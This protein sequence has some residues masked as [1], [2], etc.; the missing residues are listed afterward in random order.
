MSER[1]PDDRQ[2]RSQ[3]T[4]ACHVLLLTM[5]QETPVRLTY[6]RAE[7]FALQQV[8]GILAHTHT[9]TRT[10]AH[11]HSRLAHHHQHPELAPA[12]DTHDDRT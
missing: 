9:R 2:R 1:A 3:L 11:T 8:S 10:R 6:T 5:Q 7:I 12:H 4:R